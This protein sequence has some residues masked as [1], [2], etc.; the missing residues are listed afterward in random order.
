MLLHHRDIAKKVTQNRQT[1]HPQQA[2][3]DVI[4]REFA[5]R[6]LRHTSHKR[7][8]RAHKRHKPRRND[9]DATVFFIK[10]MRLVEGFF[11]EKLGIF[12]FEH[13]GAEI[14]TNRVVR[15]I[16]QHRS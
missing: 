6:H 1:R 15:L 12:P 5:T 13:F 9:G 11:V 2:T 4:Q 8:K 10:I 16:P 14:M 7:R 3:G